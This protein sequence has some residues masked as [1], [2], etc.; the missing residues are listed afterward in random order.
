MEFKKSYEIT[1]TI[2]DHV[3]ELIDNNIIC[4][5]GI[6]LQYSDNCRYDAEE[7]KLYLGSNKPCVI[8]AGDKKQM[9]I[10]KTWYEQIN[11]EYAKYLLKT[12]PGAPSCVCANTLT[13]V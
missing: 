2:P 9:K 3:F 13:G 8:K 10:L 6:A 5:G 12:T 11:I 7:K 4:S 1:F